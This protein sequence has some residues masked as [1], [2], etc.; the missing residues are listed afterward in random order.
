LAFAAFFPT[1]GHAAAWGVL[2]AGC[3]EVILV[4][5]DAARVG[6]LPRFGWPRF[7]TDLKRFFRALLPA[8]VG[9]SGVEIALISDTFLAS[10]LAPGALSALYFADR[11][12]QLPI[13]IIGI[14]AGTV[15]L[16]EMARRI[17]SGDEAGARRAQNQAIELT[18]LLSIPFLV[19]FLLVP[20]LIMRALFARGKFTSAD[21]AAAAQTL[22]AYA[23]GLLPFVLIRSVVATF[24]ARGNTATPVYASLTAVAVNVA[25]K[26][27][28]VLTTTLA[29][30]GLALA[31]SIGAWVNLTLVVWFAWRAR[32]IE[33]DLGLRRAMLKILAAGLILALALWLTAEPLAR[34]FSHW[35]ALRDEATLALL[36]VIGA[37][38]Y[39]GAA[40]ALFGRQWLAALR[41]RARGKL[42]DKI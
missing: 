5:G 41:R 37:I 24:F 31:T 33:F 28:F 23:L 30:V 25:C 17:A 2:M 7:D 14:A 29:Q 18:L 20:D 32:L 21:A 22:T 4:A 12:N 1:A 9:S 40:L 39:W 38:S 10:L 34:L 15:L 35:P 42:P 11:I 6:V 13:G 8:M 27:I 26:A 36:V 3:L 16:P 19:A